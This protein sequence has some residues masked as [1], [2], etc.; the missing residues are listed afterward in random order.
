MQRPT[1]PAHHETDS[2]ARPCKNYLRMHSTEGSS[3]RQKSFLK[4]TRRVL[5]TKNWSFWKMVNYKMSLQDLAFP[6]IKDLK[7]TSISIRITIYVSD[8]VL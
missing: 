2:Q 1:R 3:D 4:T 5:E 8:A 6:I 7:K